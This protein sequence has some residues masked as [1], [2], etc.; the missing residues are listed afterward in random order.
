[1]IKRNW[2]SHV[3]IGRAKE[4]HIELR[5][6]A[7]DDLRQWLRDNLKRTGISQAALSRMLP[8]A[9]QSAINKILRGIR[10]ISADELIALENIFA[11][12]APRQGLA[13]AKPISEVKL[14]RLLGEVAGGVWREMDSI[15]FDETFLNYPLDPRWPEGSVYALRVRGNSINRQAKDGEIAVVLN[16]D[17]APR[18]FKDGDWVVVERLRRDVI[19]CTIKLVRGRPGDWLL[20]PDS[21]DP[22]FQEPLKLDDGDGE[23]VIAVKGFVLDFIRPATQL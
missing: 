16:L 17:A 21:D 20:F 5:G 2:S 7:V 1:M 18:D 6:R 14:I 19:E 12:Q 11:Q 23:D 9:P 15:D 10:E 13:S 4:G 22:R 3:Q 8:G